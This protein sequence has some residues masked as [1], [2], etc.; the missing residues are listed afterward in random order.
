MQ[1]R[2]DIRTC[3]FVLGLISSTLVGAE[4]LE[5][6]GW[7]ATRTPIGQ[8]TGLCLP[9][10]LSRF[11]HL[12]TWEPAKVPSGIEPLPPFT[13]LEGEVMHMISNLSNYVLAGT[14]MNNLKR[15]VLR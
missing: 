12:D 5:E 8:T 2:A 7:I 3:F 9:D 13:G 11:V 4:I 14:A 10:D 1:A 6:C 15:Y